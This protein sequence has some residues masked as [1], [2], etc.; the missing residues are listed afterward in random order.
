M[1][2]HDPTAGR[3]AAQTSDNLEG[4]PFH[5]DP[6]D[7][8]DADTLP[9]GEKY[10]KQRETVRNNHPTGLV[11]THTGVDVQRAEQ[12]FAELNKQLS[13][14]SQ[15][16]RRLSRTASRTSH[17]IPGEKDVEKTGSS[18]DSEEPWDLETTLRGSKAAEHEAGI[19]SKR[20][21]S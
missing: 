7:A 6:H 11:Q 9:D 5:H 2:K 14:I 13:H 20:I 10:E 12:E 16:S 3:D 8:S 4:K 1:E 17:R 19:K 21:G 18:S 15:Q